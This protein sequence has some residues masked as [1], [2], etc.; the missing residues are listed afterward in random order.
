MALERIHEEWQRLGCLALLERQ[1][2]I[3]RE[4]WL[5]I[6]INTILVSLSVSGAFYEL[7]ALAS[8]TCQ[9]SVATLEELLGKILQGRDPVLANTLD[10]L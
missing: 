2:D 3:E 7:D 1:R 6:C 9:A 4:C 10:V 5:A 8:K